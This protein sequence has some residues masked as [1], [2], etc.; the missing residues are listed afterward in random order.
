MQP[1]TIFQFRLANHAINAI[2][3]QD[4]RPGRAAS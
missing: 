3:D 2:N 1:A 4:D